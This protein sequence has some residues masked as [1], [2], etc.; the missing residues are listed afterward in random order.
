MNTSS[1]WMQQVTLTGNDY[2]LVY[3]VFSLV[4]ASMFA[5]FV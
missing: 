5:A 1:Q 3:N 4:V 2:L